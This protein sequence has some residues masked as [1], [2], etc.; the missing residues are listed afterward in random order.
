MQRALII[1]DNEEFC[2]FLA[3]LLR[4]RF[5]S[6]DVATATSCRE[7]LAR[8][9]LFKPHCVFL[10]IQLADGNGL[11][12]ARTFRGR[13]PAVTII[14]VTNHDLPEYRDAATQYGANHFLPKSS[15]SPSQI[16]SLVEGIVG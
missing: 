5:A 15:T 13:D 4:G 3:Q 7:G 8:F 11:D 6:M 2:G 9:T 1:D 10:D 16:I 12:L 14:V